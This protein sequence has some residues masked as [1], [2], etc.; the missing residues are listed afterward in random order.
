MEHIKHAVYINL[1]KRTDR[2]AEFEAECTRMGITVDRFPAIE[3]KPGMIGCLKSHLAVL[4]HARDNN[5]DHVLIFEDDFEFLVSPEK[6]QSLLTDFFESDI[7]YD[8]VMLSYSL[9]KD[10]PFNTLLGK[11]LEAQTASGYLVHKRFYNTLI[12]NFEHH[13][14]LLIE[15]GKHWLHM[16]DQ[17]WKSLQP[18][19]AWYYFHI[20]IGKQR[21]SYSDN[22]E[23][24]ENYN[25]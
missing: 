17:C 2:R 9:Q 4:Q 22:T 12:E 5:W 11:V 8:V 1:E 6:F 18:H 25:I 3:A 10:E 15:T 14:P 7:V 21:P 23:R 13:L 16:N 20:R 19:A 24:F